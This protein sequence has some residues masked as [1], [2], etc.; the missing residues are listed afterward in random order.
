MPCSPIMGAS[1]QFF[2]DSSQNNF[3]LRGECIQLRVLI[4][5]DGGDCLIFTRAPRNLIW[6][7]SRAS[8]GFAACG[9]APLESASDLRGS[10]HD[11]V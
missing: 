4:E 5:L 6:S 9:R 1:L 8:T 7:P 10:A 2:V 11:P 3:P